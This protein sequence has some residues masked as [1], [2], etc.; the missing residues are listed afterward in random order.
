M[1]R[2]AGCLD[3][4]ARVF[5]LLDAPGAE[6][7]VRAGLG[8]GLGERDAEAGRGPGDD[9]DFSFEAEAVQDRHARQR[10]PAAP[11]EGRGRGVACAVERRS[12]VRVDGQMPVVE[13]EHALRVHDRELDLDRRSWCRSRRREAAWTAPSRGLPPGR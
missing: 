10:T 1:A 8:E 6:G 3:E 9:G 12:D 7:D 4:R 2:A 11:R 5:E 13:R